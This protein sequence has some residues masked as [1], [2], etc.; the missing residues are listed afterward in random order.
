M[1]ADDQPVVLGRSQLRGI[2]EQLPHLFGV[3]GVEAVVGFERR[4]FAPF[5]RRVVTDLLQDGRRMFLGLVADQ[6]A[7]V[8]RDLVR[9]GRTDAL[10]VA[11]VIVDQ[12]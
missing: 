10:D 3:S 11:L 7:P 6:N 9:H 2:G 4:S 5:R 1:A 8:A 12:A